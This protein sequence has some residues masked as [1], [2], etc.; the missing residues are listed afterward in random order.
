MQQLRA[1][2]LI[3]DEA[4]QKGCGG[5]SMGPIRPPGNSE[6]LQQ[7]PA[8]G[9]LPPAA[10]VDSVQ[11]LAGAPGASGDISSILQDLLK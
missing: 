5:K 9:F 8:L 6:L 3:M 11:P 4:L 2:F 7:Q 1:Q 10:G